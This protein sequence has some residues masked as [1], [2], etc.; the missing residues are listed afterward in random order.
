MKKKIPE[1]VNST[2]KIFDRINS[3]E[4]LH[5]IKRS[6]KSV[7]SSSGCEEDANIKQA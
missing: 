4:T 6:K 2:I 5:S 7:A 3:L 1:D